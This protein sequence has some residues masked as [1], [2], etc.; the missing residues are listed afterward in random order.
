MNPI[1]VVRPSKSSLRSGQESYLPFERMSLWIESLEIGQ[2]T[3]SSDTLGLKDI[4]LLP[5]ECR[6]AK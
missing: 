6:I 5:E 2:P 4:R 3:K 1:D